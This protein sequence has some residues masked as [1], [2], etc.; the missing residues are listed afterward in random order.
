[1]AVWPASDTVTQYEFHFQLP[2]SEATHPITILLHQRCI[3]SLTDSFKEGREPTPGSDAAAA[4]TA[5]ELAAMSLS[6]GSEPAPANVEDDKFCS[7]CGETDDDLKGCNGCRGIR[8]CSAKCQKKH[9]K[10]HK[11]ECKRIAAVL[12]KGIPGGGK[13]YLDISEQ[14]D[15]EE[16]GLFN[17]PPKN[18]DCVICMVRLPLEAV[19]STYWAC[20]GKTICSACYFDNKNAIAKINQKKAEKKQKLLDEK[21]CPFCRAPSTKTGQEWIARANKRVQLGDA[22]AIWMIGGVYRDGSGMARDESKALQFLEKAADLG[23]SDARYDLGCAYRNGIP[24]VEIDVNMAN[25]H[26]EL[27]AKSGHALARHNIGC[28][29][30]RRADVGLAIKH[31]RISAAAGYTDSVDG[32]IGRFETGFICHQDLAPSLRARD[33]AR[34]EMKSESRDRY[35]AHLKRTGQVDKLPKNDSFC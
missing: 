4:A 10:V 6:G 18:P 15:G 28:N 11:K 1:M 34:L 17:E 29:L 7:N 22:D 30:L 9:W 35:V 32:L 19:M 25:M 12:K 14:V 31:W 21:M 27:A 5:D 3:V 20:C 24:G 26:F 33:K 23:S 2:T 13:Y 16:S 8:Y